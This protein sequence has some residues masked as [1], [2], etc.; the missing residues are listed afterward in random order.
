[1]FH[2][3]NVMLFVAVS[4]LILGVGLAVRVFLGSR[5]EKPAQFRDYFGPQFDGGLQRQSAFSDTEDWPTDRQPRFA[6][7][8]LR[9]SETSQRS[10]KVNGDSY[11]DR[12][13]D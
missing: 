2:F 9:G 4:F 8:R 5:R 11:W 3:T 12:D 1:M 7:F 13:S 6:P 10:A